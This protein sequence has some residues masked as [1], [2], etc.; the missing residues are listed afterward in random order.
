MDGFN[1]D[2][3]GIIMASSSPRRIAILKAH[4]V[5]PIAVLSP[6]IDEDAITSTFKGAPE[7]LAERLASA[8]AQKV[9]EYLDTTT[10]PS[11]P[12]GVSPYPPGTIVLAADTI[13]YDGTLLGKPDDEDAAVE[14][15]M[16]LSGKT[17][18]VITGVALVDIATKRHTR[19]HDVT[20]VTFDVYDEDA[21]RA[22]ANTGEPLDKSGSYAVQGGWK[23]HVVNIDG[24]VEDVVGLPWHIVPDMLSRLC[25]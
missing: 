6:G 4:G 1:Q 11:M 18:S 19:S 16:R 23:D 20:R 15:L 5:Q 25:R 8:K 2:F 12:I 10:R 24:D 13:V 9:V 3:P 21:A 14:M 7:E 22:Y 17:H